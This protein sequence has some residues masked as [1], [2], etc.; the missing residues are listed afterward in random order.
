MKK[1]DVDRMIDH[2]AEGLARE[3]DREVLWGMLENM[4]WTRV[5]IPIRSSNV[6]TQDIT[7][8]ARD[9]CKFP[10]ETDGRDFLFEN[11]KDAMWFKM[12][13]LS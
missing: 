12:R 13:W 3:I 4:G 2:A 9:N 1:S 5:I 6:F 7:G 8:W 11:D 10:Y